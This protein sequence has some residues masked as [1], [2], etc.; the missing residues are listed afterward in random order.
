M[1]TTHI[2][3]SGGLLAI[4]AIIFAESGMMLGFFL[5]GDTLLLSAGILAA[6]GKLPLAMTIAVVALAAILGDNTGYSLGRT[7]G[8]RLFRKK[9]GILFRQEYVER[10]EKFYEKYGSKTMLLSHFIPVVRSF[11]PL[12]AGVGKMPRAQFFFFDAIGD[13]VWAV[14]TT[15]VGYWFGSRIKN[16]DHYIL[17]TFIAVVILTFAPTLWHIFGNR[18]TRQRLFAAMRRKSR[19]NTTE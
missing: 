12:V 10:A 2:I 6:Q 5:P 14:I 8:P 18:E 13:V 7:M 15:L 1:D 19:G 4:G 17:P 11:A 3:Q 16:L 9:D